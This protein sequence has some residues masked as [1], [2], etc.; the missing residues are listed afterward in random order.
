M[1][2]DWEGWLPLNR[3]ESWP[4]CDTSLDHWLVYTVASRCVQVLSWYKLNTRFVFVCC[5]S[6]MAV[7]ASCMRPVGDCW[8]LCHSRSTRHWVRSLSGGPLLAV[9]SWN[10][11]L[12]S[13]PAHPVCLRPYLCLKA[14][15]M[16]L[17]VEL[18]GL[19]LVKL[20]R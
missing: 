15:Y 19:S 12:P 2:G 14:T 9:V 4:H 11:F 5:C 16:T 7:M 20:H 18:F 10:L 1:L 17:V 13:P 8:E 3:A 6:T